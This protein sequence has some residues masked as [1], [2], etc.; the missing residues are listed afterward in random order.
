MTTVMHMHFDIFRVKPQ[1]VI[2]H[3]IKSSIQFNPNRK[4]THS[5]KKTMQY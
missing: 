5:K 2:Q 1:V 3:I 4:S